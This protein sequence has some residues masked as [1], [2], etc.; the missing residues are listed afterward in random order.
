MDE[1]VQDTNVRGIDMAEHTYILTR[2]HWLRYA[3]S[4]ATVL[5]IS[6][7][8]YRPRADAASV[9]SRYGILGQQAPELEV[10]YWIDKDGKPTRFSVAQARGKW[11]YLKCFQNWCPGCHAYGFPALKRV[12]D[13]FY[14]DDRVAVVGVQTVFEGFSVNT[15]ASVRKLQLRY[16][17]PITMGHDPGDPD[18]DHRPLTMRRYRTG[19]TPWV[20]IID[21]SGRVIFND[22]HVDAGKF[23]KYLHSQLA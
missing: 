22:F 19:G 6:T 14:D 10:D 12:A 4:T 7:L 17:L 15:Q 20:I 8:G 3:T 5:A 2:R 11:I 18:G 23:I 1:W 21:P 9:S 13:S 16:Q